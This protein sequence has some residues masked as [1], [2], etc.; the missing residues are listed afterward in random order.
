MWLYSTVFNAAPE[1]TTLSGYSNIHGSHVR[2]KESCRLLDVNI[3]WFEV[4][5]EASDH[6][7]SSGW[8]FLLNLFNKIVNKLCKMGKMSACDQW[9]LQNGHQFG[10]K[11]SQQIQIHNF[12]NTAHRQLHLLSHRAAFVFHPCCSARTSWL[13]APCALRSN[14]HAREGKNQNRWLRQPAFNF[15]AINNMLPIDILEFVVNAIRERNSS[16]CVRA[17]GLWATGVC[18]LCCACAYVL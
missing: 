17:R 14:R 3:E 11:C 6:A 10:D 12:W 8:S 7:S 2:I 15:S 5:S 18:V 4:T 13:R 9:E 16:D 1:G